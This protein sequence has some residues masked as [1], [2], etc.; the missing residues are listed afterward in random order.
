MPVSGNDACDRFA[1]DAT[2]SDNA[3]RHGV[4]EQVAVE[5][6]GRGEDPGGDPSTRDRHFEVELLRFMRG[7]EVDDDDWDEQ[8]LRRESSVEE[9][10]PAARLEDCQP[11]RDDDIEVAA[12]PE[13]DKRYAFGSLRSRA[14]LAGP[15]P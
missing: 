9:L 15:T 5:D 7:F 4:R 12:H 13:R 2:A 14:A 11:F 8:L 6:N 1:V 10:L 3:E